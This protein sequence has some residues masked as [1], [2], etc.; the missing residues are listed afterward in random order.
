MTRT[1][2]V[3]PYP[4]KPV[5]SFFEVAIGNEQIELKPEW[6]RVFAPSDRAVEPRKAA[7]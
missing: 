4:F 2:R 6:Q 1:S 3:I 7:A 5:K